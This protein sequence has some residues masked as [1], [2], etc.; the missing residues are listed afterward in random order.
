MIYDRSVSTVTEN[1]KRITLIGLTLPLLTEYIF[2]QLYSTVNT[3]ILSGYSDMAVSAT[4][5]SQQVSSLATVILDMINKGVVIVSSVALGSQDKE[6]A[7]SLAGTGSVMAC[8]DSPG[9][10]LNT[11]GHTPGHSPHWIQVS[12]WTY[13]CIFLPPFAKQIGDSMPANRGN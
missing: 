13:A 9:R 4:G 8:A 3:V 2:L 1:G 7:R 12:R 6:R 10:M 11:S 5:V